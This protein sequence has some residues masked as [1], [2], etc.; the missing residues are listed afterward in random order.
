[1]NEF[2]DTIQDEQD[3]ELD[4]M[5]QANQVLEQ[6]TLAIETKRLQ[7]VQS[8]IN[9]LKR[10][11]SKYN[12]L[13]EFKT[14]LQSDM[15]LLK[16][17]E[18]QEKN[19][20]D[21]LNN[22][23]SF[24]DS[25]ET[26]T[27]RERLIRI[28]KLNPLALD[29]IDE[30][31]QDSNPENE[32]MQSLF[33]GDLHSDS[34]LSF[35]DDVDEYSDHEHV[36][37]DRYKDD[38]DE[39]SYQRR[40]EKWV[41]KRRRKRFLFQNPGFEIDSSFD[42]TK[43]LD[44]EVHEPALYVKDGRMDKGFKIPGD[45]FSHLFDYQKTC[46]RW[47][48][49]L[50][51]QEVGGVLGDEMGLGKTIQIISFLA[52]LSYSKK[53]NGPILIVCP[54]TVQEWP[55]LRVII[56]HS[57][58]S[59]MGKDNS[60]K[61]YDTESETDFT[62]SED[63]YNEKK[64]RKKQKKGK[65]K[66]K[67]TRQSVKDQSIT[68]LIDKV[69]N[70]GHVI[71][72]TYSAIRIYDEHLLPVKWSYVVL[73][74][75]HKIRNPDADI[76]QACK[77]LKT[78]HR[79]ILSGTP[80]QNN[81]T[82]L[83]SL[84]DFV[85]P[86]RLGTLPVFQSEF[87]IPI[88]IGGYVNATNIQVETAYKCACILKDFISPYL[89]RRMKVDVAQQLPQKNEQVLFCKLTN[90]QRRKYERFIASDDIGRIMDGKQHVLSGI[91]TL[92]KICNH[93]D[94]LENEKD[95]E[96]YGDMERSGKMVVVHSLLEM[97]ESQGH[98]VLLFCQTRQML[99]IL[100]N[101]VKRKTEFKYRRMDGNTP[102]KN[103]SE[104]VDGFNND[105]DIF[106]FLLTTKVGG[107][108]INLTGANRVIIFDPDWNPST[109]MQARERCWRLG[110]TKTVTI[111]RLMISG[112]IEEKI[113][114][115]QIFKQFLS[116]KVLKGIYDKLILDPRQQR[117]FKSN[118]LHDL[119]S[120][121]GRD[122]DTTETDQLF[123]DM[124]VK[125]DVQQ[126]D[127]MNKINSIDKVETFFEKQENESLPNEETSG[128]KP[129]DDDTRIL[130]A[131]FSNTGVHSAL[132][133]DM[134]MNS[135]TPEAKLIEKESNMI[136]KQALNALKVSRKRVRQ[137]D[138]GVPTWTGTRGSSGRPEPS[139]SKPPPRRFGN[140]PPRADPSTALRGGILNQ[141]TVTKSGESPIGSAAILSNL[142]KRSGLT[143][144][145]ID[146]DLKP[147]LKSNLTDLTESLQR[148]L[149]SKTD[150]V[151]SSEIISN[152]KLKVNKTDMQVFRQILK[153]MADFIHQGD[154][155]G[156]KLKSEFL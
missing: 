106:L 47:L 53:L 8:K 155:K 3:L 126:D 12:Q 153:G 144:N 57:T 136:A 42:F 2:I 152:F 94:L 114:H 63:D 52:G 72:T 150:L 85:Y 113:Y 122:R 33:K 28:G 51:K 123:S 98:R 140:N 134:I 31:D 77:Q 89:L 6:Q 133:H 50:H 132:Q 79:I 95:V 15:E 84:Y 7:K 4:I 108:G 22:T 93:P 66:Y 86:G 151:S 124:N 59:G 14:K 19:I 49:E 80:I 87:S 142:R 70:D 71:V 45:V 9:E 65:N 13:N 96:N 34:D 60:K 121:E 67:Q 103:R 32:T 76:T 125:V 27:E 135:I 17:L 64:R 149:L 20:K 10:K 130:Q 145:D 109:D 92:R 156:W 18:T 29:N 16:D 116:N 30:S 83:W 11:I 41:T 143:A 119:F 100:E 154:T 78:P 117:F 38:G 23:N 36:E 107:L 54:A 62:D 55:P 120:F 58:G 105:P 35:A 137:Q 81:L 131:L 97:W 148:Y 138:I 146:I 127:E 112:S 141:S 73:D 115:R 1:M 90:Y 44:L 104:M 82:E 101:Y 110:Q 102:I 118:D 91:D 147:V 37:N 128:S 48:W 99:D 46:T 139:T 56:L 39:L 74:E 24:L 40:L 75:G 5:N 21:R 61:Q 69:V 26:E 88:N 25:N 129:V 43:D 111:Y 68:D